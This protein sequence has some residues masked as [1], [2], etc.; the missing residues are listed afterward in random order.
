VL[1]SRDPR[2]RRRAELIGACA[3][4]ILGSVCLA[5]GLSGTLLFLGFDSSWP[6][7][8]LGGFLVV[9]G[10]L[11]LWRWWAH[12]RDDSQEVAEAAKEEDAH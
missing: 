1:F 4:V 5:C 9:V 12:R 3:N 6:F 10:G 11:R 2:S 7:V 8:A